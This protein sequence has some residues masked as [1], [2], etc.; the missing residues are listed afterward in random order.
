ME[1]AILQLTPYS[2]YSTYLAQ[3]KTHLSAL[4]HEASLGVIESGK[5]YRLPPGTQQTG[6][7]SE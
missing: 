1:R 3:V 4:S 5:S 2:E 7:G 6:H